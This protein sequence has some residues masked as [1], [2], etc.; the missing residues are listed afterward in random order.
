[1]AREDFRMNVTNKGAYALMA[2]AAVLWGTSGPIAELAYDTG[3]S[4]SEVAVFASIITA[5]ILLLAVAI[6][7]RKSLWIRRKDFVPLLIFS[8]IT[9]SFFVMAWYT[10]VERTS[11][12]TAVILLYMYPSLVTIASIFTLGERLDRSKAIALP[13]TFA[14]CVLVAGAKDFEQGLAFDMIGIGLGVYAA[15][16]AAVYYIWGKKFLE[17]YSANTLVLYLMVLSLPGLILIA[18]PLDLADTS[19]SGSAWTLIFMIGLVPGTIA[20][21][22]SLIALKKIEASR[23]SII[24]SIEP[25]AAVI[26]A[27]L[28]LSDTLNIL[29]SAGVSMVFVGV[30]LLRLTQAKEPQK[31]DEALL[32][33]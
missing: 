16:A 4:A 19:L 18:N 1:M 10:C 6:F 24:A 22:V 13:L 11:T 9:G 20:F 27:Y 30:I 5:I 21:V 14:G 29:Q 28:L 7:D 17:V 33:R 2:V 26:I 8:L 15:G 32:T 3:A 25:V 23:A 31:P 12:A